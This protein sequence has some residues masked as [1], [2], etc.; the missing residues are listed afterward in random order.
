MKE[1]IDVINKHKLSDDIIEWIQLSFFDKEHNRIIDSSWKNGEYI[2][3]C[4]NIIDK[5][6][7]EDVDVAY[8]VIMFMGGNWLEFNYDD[9]V[10]RQKPSFDGFNYFITNFDDKFNIQNRNEF[11]S[12]CGFLRIVNKN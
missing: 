8:G 5:L 2:N 12:N 7:S 4:N 11:Y 1:Y 9:V 3:I 6:K 10:Y